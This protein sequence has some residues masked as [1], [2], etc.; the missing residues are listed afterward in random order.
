MRYLKACVAWS[1]DVGLKVK[2]ECLLIDSS[3]YV[4]NI[5][6][7]LPVK[8]EEFFMLLSLGIVCWHFI[9]QLKQYGCDESFV[10]R[11]FRHF[12]WVMR[13]G[14][15]VCERNKV[16][17]ATMLP[18]PSNF[19]VRH[20]GLWYSHWPTNFWQ[21]QWCLCYVWRG[22]LISLQWGIWRQ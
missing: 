8:R 3:F 1:N 2:K 11:H 16:L 6:L 21:R 4:L 7:T 19:M 13:A 9:G 12:N 20:G 10:Y 15:F 22:W 17:C 14:N 5:C 18:A